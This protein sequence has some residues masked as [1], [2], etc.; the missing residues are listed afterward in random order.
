MNWGPGLAVARAACRASSRS[1]R[2]SLNK[3]QASPGR[4]RRVSQPIRPIYRDGTLCY[5]L[6]VSRTSWRLFQK[7]VP[8][9]WLGTGTSRAT[10]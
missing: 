6:G 8:H 5:T 1:R 2:K 4:F 7:E 10:A 9:G 3:K